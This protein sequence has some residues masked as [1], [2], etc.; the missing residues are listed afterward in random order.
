MK[1]T[2][3][4]AHYQGKIKTLYGYQSNNLIYSELMD[5]DSIRI[6]SPIYG[7]KYV[8][9]GKERYIM[10]SKIH[11]VNEGQYL[12]VNKGESF[13]CN[14]KSNVPVQ[15]LCV[16]IDE[17]ILA[18]VMH[19]KRTKDETLLDN[20]YAEPPPFEGLHQLVYSKGN[21]LSLYLQKLS[22][23]LIHSKGKNAPTYDLFYELTIQLLKAHKD[24]SSQIHKIKASKLST[25][26]E[27]YARLEIAKSI[28][29]LEFHQPIK[30]ADVASKAALSEFHFYRCFKNVYGISPHKFILQKKDRQISRDDQ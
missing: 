5:I 1:I 11:E 20:P 25:K 26:R 12:L 28:L 3:P 30:M 16:G 13:E 2:T 18:G 8:T 4:K 21:S 29:E 19:E 7:I 22:Q 15:G 23:K 24:S 9:A 14:F 17:K 10:G 27:L 6:H